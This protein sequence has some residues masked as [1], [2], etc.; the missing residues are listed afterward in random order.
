ML[1]LAFFQKRVALLF[2][3][4]RLELC[5]ISHG[6]NIPRVTPA[7]QSG[8]HSDPRETQL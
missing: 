8:S 3:S 7:V 4:V 5:S 2:I 6:K 1:Y